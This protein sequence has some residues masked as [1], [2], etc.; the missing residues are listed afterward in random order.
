[1]KNISV[2]IDLTDTD[3]EELEDLWV[4]ATNK[5]LEAAENVWES[6]MKTVAMGLM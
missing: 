6:E 5:A 4:I 1:M 3:K 2:N